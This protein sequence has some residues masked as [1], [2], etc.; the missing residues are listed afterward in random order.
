MKAVSF[1]AFGGPEVL[2]TVDVPDPIPR[3]GQVRVAVRAA[4]VNYFDAKV[5]AGSMEPMF[6]TPLP[7]FPGLEL[8]GVVDLLGDGVDDVAVGD[9][10]VGW[11]AGPTG[12]YAD[13]ALLKTYA[14]IPGQV[15]DSV[16]ASLPVASEAARRG[17]DALEIDDQDTLLIH[18]ASGSVGAVA[19]QLAVRRGATVIATASAAHHEKL[20]AFGALP[21]SYSDGWAE[22]VSELIP[23][24]V[25][26]VLD[27]AGRGMLPDSIRLV[28]GTDRVLTFADPEATELG[29]AFSS[30]ARINAGDLAEALDDVARGDL[31]ITVAHVLPMSDAVEAHRILDGGHAGGKIVLIPQES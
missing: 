14:R 7:A 13:K 3:T 22:R 21:V 27:F 10:V 8:A 26:A 28:G 12:A 6:S 15:S 18:G 4:A 16:A 2:K 25:D 23:G 17:L 9:R 30:A 20:R 11:S 19:V 1:S 24:G 5:R 29:V 31:V